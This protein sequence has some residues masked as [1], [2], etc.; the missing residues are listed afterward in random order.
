MESALKLVLVSLAVC[1][2]LVATAGAAETAHRMD[3]CNVVWQTPSK[4]S[5]GSMPLGNGSTGL[6]AWVEEN[7]DLLFYISRIDSWGDNARLLK[8]GRVRIA[9]DPRPQASS[10]GFRQTLSLKDAT[11]IVRYGEGEAVELRLWADANHPV[12]HVAV[13]SPQPIAATA[14]M[15][16]W[17]TKRE[18][19]PSVEVSDVLLERS[20]P[21][22]K[23]GPTVV[24]PDTVLKN[25]TGRIGWYH[26]NVKSV[27][28][29]MTGEIQGLEGFERPDP[30]LGRTFG[31]VI[32][33][34]G[35]RRLDDLNLQS[36][37]SKAHRF[38]IY[39][40]TQHPA[41]PEQWLKVMDEAIAATQKIPFAR[42]R[43]AHERWWHD[44]WD[45]S[46]ISV[47]SSGPS[48]TLRLVPANT[49]PV[50]IGFDQG[51]GNRFAGEIGRLSLYGKALSDA[52]VQRL[53][54]LQRSEPPED[55]EG[56][57]YGGAPK[58]HAALDGSEDWAFE[59]GLTIEAWIKPEKMGSGGG[60]LVDNITPGGSD[61]FL[62]D[63]WP[64]NGLRLIVGRAT[65]GKRDV[66][67]A[68]QWS[69]VAAVVDPATGKTTLY[70]GGT[71]LA[72][73]AV[74]AGDDAAV[75]SRAYALQ[76]FITACAGR[77]AYPIKFNGTIFTVPYPN[78]PGDADYRRWGPGYWWQNTRLPY[79]SLCTSG[80][81]DLMQPFFKMYGRDLMPLLK[82]RTRLYLGHGGA[83]IPECIYFW[84]DMFS[85]TYGWTPYHERKDRLQASGW[86]KWEW[87]SGPELVHMMLDYY[88][89]TLEEAFLAETL[90]P[91]AHEILTFFDEHYKVDE[92]GKL[93]MH[94]SQACET[95]WDC[96]NPMPEVAG[97]H[98]ATDRLLTLPAGLTTETQRTFWTALRKK[99]PDLPTREVDGKRMLAPAERFASK[100]NS[101]NPELYA[102][103]PFRRIAIGRPG[104][105]LGIEALR[106]RW[107]KGNSGWRQDD[108]FMAYLGLADEARTNLVGRARK[109]HD[110]SRFPAFWGP[111]YDWIPDQDHGGVLMKALQ[112]MLLQTDG[113]K[114]YLL[115][116]WP[117]DWDVEFR[118]HAPYKTTVECTVRGGKVR[119]LTVTPSERRAD[120]VTMEP[121]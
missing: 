57:L 90:L 58:P 75:V 42:R 88:D 89:H 6:N 8:V 66:L 93:V 39:V 105:E 28:P 116:A 63:T 60:R 92:R 3:A 71:P 35:G 111:N 7:G 1:V 87:V 62:L 100:R 120:L 52:A 27:G 91:A 47:T 43:E 97:L 113:R 109:K 98:A 82:F 11:M 95:W 13:D 40:A 108:I 15:E 76:R 36:P 51:G 50:R 10:P 65:L 25:Q 54:K 79:I 31:A 74:E 23:H 12:I 83:Y 24:E 115:P 49:H 41:T 96:T 73:Q 38:D 14:S 33:A 121:Q 55:R 102:V 46:W 84:G 101:E 45:R 44:F 21:G 81:F 69:H 104:V 67:P 117:K 86:H 114:M 110:G 72:E 107:D 9:L 32:R 48:Q 59:K 80:D 16:L 77:G 19:L 78:R 106:H 85:E 34:E 2:P 22:K 64:G 4:D 17:R 118:L 70:L 119:K 5:S 56:L 94:P 18:E 68:G 103:F 53:A 29:A 37:A 26:R 30:L 99:L 20:K 61:G 112:A